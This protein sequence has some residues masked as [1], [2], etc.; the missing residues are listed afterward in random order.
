M[1]QMKQ[2]TI[3]ALIAVAVVGVAMAVPARSSRAEPAADDCPN[4]RAARRRRKPLVLPYGPV[5]QSPLLAPGAA[6]E[7]AKE[8]REVAPSKPQPASR[9][10]PEPKAEPPAEPLV[11]TATPLPYVPMP[12]QGLAPAAHR[13]GAGTCRCVIEPEPEPSIDRDA[14]Q[15]PAAPPQH[16]AGEQNG[17]PSM[18]AAASADDPGA[19]ATSDLRPSMLALV[20]AALVLAAVIVRKV[21]KLFT[22]RRLRRRRSLLRSDWEAAGETPAPVVSAFADMVALHHADVDPDAT[23]LADFSRMPAA[24]RNLSHAIAERDIEIGD[25]EATLQRLVRDLWRDCAPQ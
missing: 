24:S 1:N 14:G 21:F 25:I 11:R 8:A 12:L 3:S 9:P 5:D 10:M 20:A 23:R 4:S 16:E 17:R 18:E 13:T 7:K 19:A 15:Q 6:T 2:R 22:V